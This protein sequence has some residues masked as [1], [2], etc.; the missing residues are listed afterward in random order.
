MRT[1][2]AVAS[3]GLSEPQ[4]R[5]HFAPRVAHYLLFGP[6]IV[7]SA[8]SGA[9]CIPGGDWPCGLD[10]GAPPVPVS[11]GPVGPCGCTTPCV[12][13][14][15]TVRPVLC[16]GSPGCFGAEEVCAHAGPRHS[17]KASAAMAMHVAR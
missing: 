6:T 11:R 9:A 5:G 1:A 15:R 13:G 14:G 12:S 16:E 3:R 2:V 7:L 8:P 4:E 10:A 17:A